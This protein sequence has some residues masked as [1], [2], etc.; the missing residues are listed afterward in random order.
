MRHTEKQVDKPVTTTRGAHGE[1]SHRPVEAAT[2]CQ[3]NGIADDLWARSNVIRGPN[4]AMFARRY[5]SG[6]GRSALI[7]VM[8]IMCPAGLLI[9]AS[10]N[11]SDLGAN[12]RVV[13]R[14]RV[15][16]AFS[17]AWS[18]G[19]GGRLSRGTSCDES[20]GSAA[21]TVA[22][23]C[24]KHGSEGAR[25]FN[26]NARERSLAALWACPFTFF[27]LVSAKNA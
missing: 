6:Q 2:A 27:G 7:S 8:K 3:R 9:G 18:D 11:W 26:Q 22:G 20:S 13:C 15:T 12:C 21:S 1:F 16:R 25:V 19:C 14:I 4:P 23:S 17:V 10:H 5:E 24:T